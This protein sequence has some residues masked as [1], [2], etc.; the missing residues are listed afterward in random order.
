VTMIIGIAD[1]TFAVHGVSFNGI[2]IGSVAALA[3]YHLLK[4]LGTATGVIKDSS[5]YITEKADTAPLSGTG[6]DENISPGE[7]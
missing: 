7:R 4:L 1:F 6:R 3:V 2:A 5:D